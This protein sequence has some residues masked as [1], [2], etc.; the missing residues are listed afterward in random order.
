LIKLSL[1]APIVYSPC[2]L[3]PQ[4]AGFSTEI[5]EKDEFLLCFELDPVQ[6][7]SIEP[8]RE[9]LLGPLLFSGLKSLS[10]PE[11]GASSTL[12]E[13]DRVSLPE[14]EYLFVQRRETRSFAAIETE[15][16]LDLAV[17]LQKDGLWERHKLENLLYARFL[18]EDGMWV[19][20]LFRP[21]SAD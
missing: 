2:R 6:G 20:Q 12:E 14:G 7:Q 5:T 15:H 9:R 8:E 3:E 13:R 1:K 18:F 19:S 4:N 16:W 10:G 21:L 11:T 17:E